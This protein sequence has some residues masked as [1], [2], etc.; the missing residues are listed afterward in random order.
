MVALIANVPGLF[1]VAVCGIYGT[2][3]AHP[4]EATM[5]VLLDVNLS[6]LEGFQCLQE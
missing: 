3:G 4:S 5:G 2:D 6:G 1:C